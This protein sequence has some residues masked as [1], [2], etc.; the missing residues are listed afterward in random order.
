MDGGNTHTHPS[1]W[2]PSGKYTRHTN[3]AQIHF[4]SSSLFLMAFLPFL[5]KCSLIDRLI[6]C[7][8]HQLGSFLPLSRYRLRTI[9][10]FL[11]SFAAHSHSLLFFLSHSRS[12][13]TLLSLS[14]SAP[15]PSIYNLFGFTIP[16]LCVRAREVV[17]FYKDKGAPS[18]LKYP[19]FPKLGSLAGH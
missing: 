11:P 13:L 9:P 3:T 15:A 1:A 6:L 2:R 16:N 18:L 10:F 17:A 7:L 5:H 14:V 19:R 4:I 8:P 12:L